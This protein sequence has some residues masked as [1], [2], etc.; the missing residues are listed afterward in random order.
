MRNLFV[1]IDY[2]LFW[3]PAFAGMTK[4]RNLKLFDFLTSQGYNEVNVISNF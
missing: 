4:E 3:I 2:L 1:R